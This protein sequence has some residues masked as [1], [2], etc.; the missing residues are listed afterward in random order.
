MI[1]DII[2][3]PS[4]PMVKPIVGGA[5]AAETPAQ[6]ITKTLFTS[7]KDITR[8]FANYPVSF[9]TGMP[10]P[11]GAINDNIAPL[12]YGNQE[13]FGL[14]H[15]EGVGSNA[16]SNRTQLVVAYDGTN[17]DA[18]FVSV[19][20]NSVTYIRASASTG[21]VLGTAFV[22]GTMRQAVFF[23][24]Q[25]VLAAASGFDEPDNTQ[26]EITWSI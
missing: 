23:T 1:N 14:Y 20:V 12:S 11:L 5:A 10:I 6:F 21:V 9:Q 19:T 16:G 24:F 22:D 2:T 4:K 25:N 8:G 17:G 7:A 15:M 13:I 18:G 3:D 26:L